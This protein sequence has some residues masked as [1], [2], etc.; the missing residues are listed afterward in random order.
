MAITLKLATQDT[1]EPWQAALPDPLVDPPTDA[2]APARLLDLDYAREGLPSA[3]PRSLIRAAGRWLARAAKAVGWLVGAALLVLAFAL[4]I[5]ATILRLAFAA[6]AALL[7]GL[8]RLSPFRAYDWLRF[9]GK[10]PFAQA[11]SP[12]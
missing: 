3:R 6:G 5:A 2:V 12:H 8:R 9:R 10:V 7:L 11:A 4:L 1:P